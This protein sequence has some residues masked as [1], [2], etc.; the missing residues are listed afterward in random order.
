MSQ[1]NKIALV[2][3]IMIGTLVQII[4]AARESSESIAGS[5]VSAAGPGAALS[6]SRR[7]PPRNSA[8]L[9]AEVAVSSAR[10]RGESLK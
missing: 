6:S 2:S 4:L 5:R 9:K 10:R 3:V 1:K 8:T 7:S